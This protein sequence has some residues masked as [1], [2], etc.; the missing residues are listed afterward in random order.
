MYTWKSKGEECLFIHKMHVWG[1]GENEVG[2]GGGGARNPASCPML[3]PRT[4]PYGRE[5]TPEQ[6][7]KYLSCELSVHQ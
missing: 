2:E 3:P 7:V 5:M 4:I 1:K 6:T